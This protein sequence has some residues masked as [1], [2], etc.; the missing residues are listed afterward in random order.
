L[1]DSG[2]GV[3]GWT[4]TVDGTT[5]TSGAAGGSSA[6]TWD[7]SGLGTG[8]HTL[9]LTA[10]DALGNSDSITVTV[11]LEAEPPVVPPV[12]IVNTSRTATPTS[13]TQALPHSQITLG[14]AKF[15]SGVAGGFG[16]TPTA[17]PTATGGTVTFGSVDSSGE[18]AA[19]AEG[20]PNLLWGL[21]ALGLIGAITA[22]VLD[23]RKK[24]KEEE[25][26]QLAEAQ[27]KAAALNAAEEQKRIQNWM[28]GF[29][30]K[31]DEDKQSTSLYTE[32]TDNGY[33]EK[34]VGENLSKQKVT[35]KSVGIESNKNTSIYLDDREG[36]SNWKK[37]DNIYNQ[38]NVKEGKLSEL[39]NGK[40]I[41]N[42]KLV[43]LTL[44]GSIWAIVL[45]IVGTL[46]AFGLLYDNS[47]RHQPNFICNSTPF[48]SIS[49][50]ECFVQ[51]GRMD[52]TQNP[53]ISWNEF[54]D[55]LNVVYE[56]LD[57]KW[58]TIIDIFSRDRYDTPFYTGNP[59]FG[60]QEN[61]NTTVC[62]EN[63]CDP[64]SYIN[65]V[66]QGM[67]SA[68][69]GET[70]ETAIWWVEFW[71]DL[72]HS[73]RLGHSDSADPR[74]L[75]WTAYGWYYSTERADCEDDGAITD[76]YPVDWLVFTCG[77]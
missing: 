42:K 24:R 59:N 8:D 60:N 73:W 11:R 71:N 74:E 38:N 32:N 7:G 40:N 45:F 57:G 12:V 31:N 67:Y 17:R 54:Q 21:G 44:L 72:V 14:G 33:L 77:E 19:Q 6:F 66:A 51:E 63:I 75:W 2:S 29:D 5:L 62:I 58:R 27:A 53:N 30:L 34:S 23:E 64:Q 1:Q 41:V 49:L 47:R 28:N 16:L 20:S 50:A 52:F 56:D 26:R 13:T 35:V 9:L 36:I 3:A 4:L 68:Q 70:L 37:V 18:A 76:T 48:S 65:Y 46:L 15:A 43:G 22:V 39:S 25:A 69:A 55:L 61:P 10:V